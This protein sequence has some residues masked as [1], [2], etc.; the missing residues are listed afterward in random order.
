[1]RYIYI[2]SE[3]KVERMAFEVNIFNDKFLASA[4]AFSRK[5]K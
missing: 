5:L 1:M 3:E 4:C 2:V